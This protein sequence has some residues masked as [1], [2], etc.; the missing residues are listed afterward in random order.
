MYTEYT[1][2]WCMLYVL[3]KIIRKNIVTHT[4]YTFTL[5]VKIFELIYL[6]LVKIYVNF[7]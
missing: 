6:A 3:K 1:F 4:K 5:C 2:T 7:V